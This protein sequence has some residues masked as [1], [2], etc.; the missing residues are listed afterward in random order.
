[1]G[2]NTRH[3]Q[4]V[5]S[6]C[7]HLSPCRY[8]LRCPLSSPCLRMSLGSKLPR[9]WLMLFIGNKGTWRYLL[10]RTQGSVPIH[11]LPSHSPRLTF[12]PCQLLP[13]RLRHDVTPEGHGKTREGD[14]APCLLWLLLVSPLEQPFPLAL[15]V[16]SG[17]CFFPTSLDQPVTQSPGLQPQGDRPATI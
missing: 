16:A 7:H 9:S 14:C 17:S 2:R 11:K 4:T 15:A 13:V 3:L 6:Q 10:R 1:M 8:L 12:L 5:A